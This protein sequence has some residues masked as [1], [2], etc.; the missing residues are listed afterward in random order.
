MKE[1]NRAFESTCHVTPC[2]ESRN[3]E[4]TSFLQGKSCTSRICPWITLSCKL[5]TFSRRM[6]LKPS[7][8]YILSSLSCLV[9]F[10]NVLRTLSRFLSSSSLLGTQVWKFRAQ[11]FHDFLMSEVLVI[12]LYARKVFFHEQ[13]KAVRGACLRRAILFQLRNELQAS[14]REDNW[15]FFLRYARKHIAVWFW[16]GG[17]KFRVY[18]GIRTCD[19]SSS[20]RSLLLEFGDCLINGILAGF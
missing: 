16:K 7:Q 10:S 8:F 1:N 18:L 4:G 2:V 3:F 11:R 9:L 19:N 6:S 15:F 12:F 20:F 5:Q 14:R 17:P 13:G